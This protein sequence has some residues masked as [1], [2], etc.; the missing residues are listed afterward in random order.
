MT[1]RSLGVLGIALLL[2]FCAKKETPPAADT[3]ATS[4]TDTATAGTETSPP[5]FPL[6]HFKFW[7][8]KS[9]P[10]KARGGLKG[11]FDKESFQAR[12]G[13]LDYLGNP[14]DKNGEGIQNEKMHLLGYSFETGRQPERSV[15][16]RN[17]L[18]V[19]E[20][21][22]MVTWRIGQPTL[23]LVPAAKAHVT[24]PP[25]PPPDDATHFACYRVLDPKPLAPPIRLVD[26]FDKKR[27]EI[28][29]IIQLMPMFFCV[30][31]A[32]THGNKEHRII[33]GKTHLAIYRI[34]PPDPFV[35]TVQ[36]VDQF[37]PQKLE[38]Q[39]SELLAVPSTKTAWN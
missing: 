38:V 1:K 28:E 16:F 14:V 11:Q 8:V 2:A 4:S 36:T 17:Q 13:S 34:D 21:N 25:P 20:P 32:K 30:P 15:T 18:T 12:V 39:N 5:A 6:D 24:E 26:Q 10:L 7:R 31:V 33:D 3:A 35:T 19:K 29:Q 9:V 27:E 22:G 23:L 37:G